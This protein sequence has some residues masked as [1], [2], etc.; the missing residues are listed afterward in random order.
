MGF[1]GS[2]K[3]STTGAIRPPEDTAPV[4][5]EPNELPLP[6]SIGLVASKL[7]TNVAVGL[8]IV[9]VTGP[10]VTGLATGFVTG[11]LTGFTTGFVTGPVVGLLTGLAT[12]F[13]TGP[14]VGLATGFVTGPVVGLATG[15]VA[16]L[17]TGLK[18]STGGLGATGLVKG[19]EK[20]STT[21]K[22]S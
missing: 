5:G 11:L 3:L 6:L 14:V 15:F 13:V 12:G 4:D 18:L 21:L 8:S 22:S 16:G 10:P 19:L 7:S 17:S 1:K 20:L 2:L 9:L